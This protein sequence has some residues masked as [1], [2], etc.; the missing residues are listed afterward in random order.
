MYHMT[1]S[2]HP[3]SHI[4]G[5]WPADTL[6]IHNISRV[7]RSPPKGKS[8]TSLWV[9]L[10]LYHTLKSHSLT[11]FVPST[12]YFCPFL[13]PF[14]ISFKVQNNLC[15]EHPLH[16]CCQ[17]RLQ[18][19]V[20]GLQE[21]RTGSVT[22]LYPWLDELYG[23]RWADLMVPGPWRMLSASSINLGNYNKIYLGGQG[24]KV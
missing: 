12:S 18:S 21:M 15:P 23:G 2:L 10:I 9:W 8:Q 7:Q 6:I 20:T 16:S 4:V 13:L 24:L 1:Q 14:P 5:Q 11:H 3:E 22:C 17:I 19:V